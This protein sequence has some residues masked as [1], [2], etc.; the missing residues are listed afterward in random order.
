MRKNK[1]RYSEIIPRTKQWPIVQLAKNRKQFVEEVA[2]ES[3]KNLQNIT[4]GRSLREELEM[5]VYREKLR[6]KANPWR[7]DPSDEKDF[8]RYIQHRLVESESIDP[9]EAK[10]MDAFTP[11]FYDM[12]GNWNRLF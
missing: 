3:F 10:K 9:K 12:L 7:V 8:W 5:T 11:S 2:E 6:I 1:V 4:R